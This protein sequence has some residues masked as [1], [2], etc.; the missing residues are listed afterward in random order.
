[1]SYK[2]FTRML[3]HYNDLSSVRLWAY[4]VLVKRFLDLPLKV[5]V[6]G[7]TSGVWCFFCCFFTCCLCLKRPSLICSF[8]FTKRCV[9]IS[10][11]FVICCSLSLSENDIGAPIIR[12]TFLYCSHI[13]IALPSL[14]IIA[15]FFIVLWCLSS[16]LSL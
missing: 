16:L 3:T 12:N 2:F 10:I 15:L 4:I 6:P 8:H 13:I 9:S 14:T 1:M 11:L 7:C 5:R